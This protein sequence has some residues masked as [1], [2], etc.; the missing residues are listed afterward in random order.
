M[1][2]GT[3]GRWDAVHVSW[4]DVQRVDDLVTRIEEP[5]VDGLLR[6]NTWLVGEVLIDAG[7]GVA[8]LRPLLP[9]VS[10]V[11]LTH[12]HLDHMGAAHEF[13]RVSAH[14]LEPVEQAG[15][16]SLQGP[17]LA[18][19]LGLPDT[20]PEL[21]IERLPHEDYDPYAYQLQPVRPSRSLGDG[22]LVGPL[23][24]IHLPGHTPGSIALYD[25]ERR[26]LFSGDV[27]YDGA[28]LDELPESNKRHY[29]R[30]LRQLLDLDI[31]TVHPGHGDSFSGDRLGELIDKYLS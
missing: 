12:A 15:R 24:V 13:D 18:R 26:T 11:V 7:L 22:D 8:P 31:E 25:Q 28:L 1:H 27:I 3:R 10:E 16:G 6:A 2:A 4:Y 5:H 19:I 14:P 30:S 20:L 29:R 23:R 9:P 17:V 21:L